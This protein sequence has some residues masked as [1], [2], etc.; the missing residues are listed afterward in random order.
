MPAGAVTIFP[1][2]LVQD[3]EYDVS[4][5]IERRIER[6]LGADLMERGV[7][8]EQLKPGEIVYLNLAGH[9]GS[10]NDTTPPGPPRHVTKRV[11]TNIHT[12]GVEVRWEPAED[13][14]WLSGYEV[15]RVEPGGVRI[16]L[17]KISKGEY[18]F[19]HSRPG[20][21]LISYRYEVCAI[22]GDGNVSPFVEAELAAGE[23]E[24]RYL[25]EGFGDVQG[26]QGWT[27]EAL[28]DGQAR[29]FLAWH[30]EAGYE[31]QWV[32][33]PKAEEEITPGMIARTFMLPHPE[34][35]IARVFTVQ[36]AGNVSLRGVVRRDLPPGTTP[37]AE[38]R[39][40]VLL[41]GQSIWPE[42]DWQQVPADL[43]GVHYDHA[44]VVRP[45]DR[46]EHVLQQN[47]NWK[48]A[49]IG[50]YGVLEYAGG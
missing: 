10:G 2:G 25:F 4:L 5:D 36:R 48:N 22:D 28:R 11:A 33:E 17:G 50:W 47:P 24:R 12:Q 26:F 32:L 1:K 37:A 39:V 18:V 42:T 3:L 7:T 34:S 45:G 31:G 8:I 6:C 43:A 30:P 44:A 13:D 23:P 38:C 29:S 35:S 16:G 9:P 49:G 14:Y 20:T 15:F 46:I 40:R 19:D 41:N 21:E 27:Y